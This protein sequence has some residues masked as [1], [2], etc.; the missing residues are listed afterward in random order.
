MLRPL[1][2]ACRA[3]PVLL[4]TTAVP[5]CSTAW[6]QISES[7]RQQLVQQIDQATASLDPQRLPE[8]EPA[9]RQLLND[10]ERLESVYASLTSP[11]NTAAWLQYL[12]VQPLVEAIQTEQP[13]AA[14]ARAALELGGRLVGVDPGLELSALRQL[15]ESIDRFVAAVRFRDPQRAINA[16][17][18]Q[19]EGLQERIENADR[20]PAAEDAAAISAIAGILTDANQAEELVS[21]LKQVFG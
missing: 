17:S 6:G 9:T 1:I 11:E 16:L 21:L 12:D 7:E 18:K 20:T 5:I 8:L 10:I 4:L 13:A 15:R 14:Q 19:L 3:I 2:I